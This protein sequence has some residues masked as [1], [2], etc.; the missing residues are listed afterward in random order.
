MGQGGEVRGHQA[1]LIRGHSWIFHNLSFRE[2]VHRPGRCTHE[3]ADRFR[4]IV[5]QFASHARR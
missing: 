5:S 4:G 1:G 3:R 2:S